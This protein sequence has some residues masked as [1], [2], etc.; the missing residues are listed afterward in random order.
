M[1]S[2]IDILDFVR[3]TFSEDWNSFVEAVNS[4]KG[5][6]TDFAEEDYDG[7]VGRLH[8]AQARLINILRRE[9]PHLIEDR[10]AIP[11]L[12][13][14]AHKSIAGSKNSQ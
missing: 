8:I 5:L 10:M 7:P 3:N 11:K 13:D 14:R 12:I 4:A 6:D 9:F 2:D 1:W